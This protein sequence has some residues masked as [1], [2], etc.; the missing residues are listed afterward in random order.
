MEKDIYE[1]ILQN[2]NAKKEIVIK[3]RKNKGIIR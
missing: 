1:M 3:K 2:Q